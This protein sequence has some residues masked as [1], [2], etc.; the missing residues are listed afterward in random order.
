ML[1]ITV[2]SMMV[3]KVLAQKEQFLGVFWMEKKII[4]KKKKEYI[5]KKRK[6]EWMKHL[7]GL[8]HDLTLS[9]SQQMQSMM[10]CSKLEKEYVPLP[11]KLQKTKHLHNKRKDE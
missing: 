7:Q 3:R 9:S 5:M 2:M 11:E 1:L 10:V 6:V 8:L 4:K